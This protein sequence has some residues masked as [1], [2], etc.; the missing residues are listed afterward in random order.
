MCLVILI[1]TL[2]QYLFLLSSLKTPW[3][4]WLHFR[5][6]F[7]IL[8]NKQH[9]W[10]LSLQHTVDT[11]G[12]HIGPQPEKTGTRFYQTVPR[13]RCQ[14]DCPHTCTLSQ[15]D[16]HDILPWVNLG[17]LVSILWSTFSSLKMFVDQKRRE[18][19]YFELVVLNF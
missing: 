16:V 5:Y 2:F 9:R 12:N 17:I 11:S 1:I 13:V 3:G 19:I 15:Q 10:V 8:W 14:G 4:Y 7:L 18:T 6:S